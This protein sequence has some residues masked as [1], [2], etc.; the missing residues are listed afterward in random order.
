MFVKSEQRSEV[1]NEFI[2]FQILLKPKIYIY[3]SKT[4]NNLYRY[5]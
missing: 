2:F 5:P 4:E 1:K 3:I